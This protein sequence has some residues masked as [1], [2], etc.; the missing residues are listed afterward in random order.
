MSQTS[1]PKKTK[2]LASN[3]GTSEVE[4]TAYTSGPAI[5]REKR[6]LQL[7]AGK[8][9]LTLSGLPETFVANSLTVTDV[10][11]EG[12]LKLG[13][14]SYR[15]ASLSLQA[16][17]EQAVGTEVTLIER[18]PA[19]EL[20]TTGK[21]L[22]VLGHQAVLDCQGRLTIAPLTDRLTL[23]PATLAGL[24]TTASLQLEPTASVAG[25]YTVGILFAADGLAWTLN[26]EV[27]YDENS[28][29]MARFACWVNLTNKSGAGIDNA[30]VK[31]IFGANTGYNDENRNSRKN[32]PRMAAM[33][34]APMGGGMALESASFDVDSAAVESV[35]AQKLYTLPDTLSIDNDETKQTLLFLSEAVPVTAEHYLGYGGYSLDPDGQYTENN[36][37]P[38]NV[39]LKVVNTKENS[40]GLALPPGS[41]KV[42]EKDSS[43]SLQRTDSSRIGDHVASGENFELAL[44]TPS[45]D[46]K[47]TRRLTFLKDDPMPPAPPAPVDGEPKKE[48]VKVPR[49]REEERE[50]V[51]YNYKDRDVEVKVQDSVPHEAEVLKE[52]TGVKG[53]ANVGGVSSF[54]VVVPKNGK[55]KVSYRIKYRIG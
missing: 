13:A 46:V 16:I 3:S 18:T 42:F 27:F 43:G 37:L 21:L 38:V 47:A 45:K 14:L 4:V 10:V 54:S 1:Q 12:R 23:D 20:K 6:Q 26:Y 30:K 32:M 39:R 24:S 35:G 34:A 52:L 53:F 2:V 49:F 29:K 36:K 31:L 44:A 5:F 48:V 19:G 50:I 7:P 51:L 28:E 55:A 25:P 17:L 41:V 40:L 9:K 15:D 11:G 33:S 22:H 8:S